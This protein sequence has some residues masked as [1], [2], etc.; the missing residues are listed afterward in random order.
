MSSDGKE[1]EWYSELTTLKREVWGWG[2]QER[3]SNFK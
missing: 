1:E 2:L 3:L